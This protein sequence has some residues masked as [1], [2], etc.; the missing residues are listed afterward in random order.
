MLIFATVVTDTD[1]LEDVNK[2]SCWCRPSLG[3]IIPSAKGRDHVGFTTERDT[4]YSYV[5]ALQETVEFMAN[6]RKLVVAFA[7]LIGTHFLAGFIILLFI[8]GLMIKTIR[9]IKKRAVRR[10]FHFST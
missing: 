2:C 6:L 7:A 9:K 1:L 3:N 10:K 4:V 5:A 8:Y